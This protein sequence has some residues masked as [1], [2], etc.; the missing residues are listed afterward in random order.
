[1]NTRTE[2]ILSC[3]D[4]KTQSGI[5]I[6]ALM[7]PIVT[8]EMGSIRYVDVATTEELK[9][10]YTDDPNVDIDEIVDVDY[11]WGDSKLADLMK[12]ASFDYVIASHVVE[13]VPDFIGWLYEIHEIL[14]TGG[15][16]SLAIPDKRY[17]FDYNRPLTT[18]GE[19]LDSFLRQSRKPSL[20]QV[21]DSRALFAS[22]NGKFSWNSSEDMANASFDFPNSEE[23]A[24]QAVCQAFH[25]DLYIDSHCWVFTPESFLVILKSLIN[26]HLF[27]FTVENFYI[28]SG[29]EFHISLK[30]IEMTSRPIGDIQSTQHKSIDVAIKEKELQ[31]APK[32]IGVDIAIKEK[33]LCEAPKEIDVDIAIKEKELCEAYEKISAME[34]SKFWKIRTQWVKIKKMYF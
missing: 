10:K 33:E 4:V 16:L 22:C 5:E 20:K 28:T 26:L 15:I 6:G 9:L 3:I 24:W 31:E 7:R 30:A 8:H 12:D 11:I 18:M 32:E 29:N 1:M 27:N 25:N 2:K 13:H 21:F 19:I 23:Y 14:K 34:S 17:C